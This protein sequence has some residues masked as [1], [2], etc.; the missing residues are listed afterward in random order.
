VARKVFYEMNLKQRIK[1]WDKTDLE[2]ERLINSVPG[3]LKKP[4]ITGGFME[5]TAQTNDA[6]LSAD[7]ANAYAKALAEFWSQLNMTE[8]QKKKS[9]IDSQ[10]PKI[11]KDLA[12]A[13][14]N[15]KQLTLMASGANL[16]L[17]AKSV[18]MQRIAR[19]VEIQ[20]TV[21]IMLRKEYE[22]AKLDA[23]KDMPPFSVIDQAQVPL[24]KS[25]PKVKLNVMIGFVLGGFIG[26]FIAFFREYW[27]KSS[28]KQ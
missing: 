1:G 26:I 4:K 25:K 2:D 8:A 5:I 28:G 19:E 11:E 16:G 7:L 24:H 12:A 17:N 10:M 13:E 21:Y 9:Y 22:T 15:L 23:A 27:E 14:A 18:E 20:N 6:K 3:M